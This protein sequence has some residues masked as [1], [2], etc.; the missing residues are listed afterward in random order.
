LYLGP[1]E[2]A[3]VL[4]DFTAYAGKTLILYNDAPA[5]DPASDPRIDYFT[6]NGDQTG[7]GGAANT[8]PGYGPNT[9]TVMQ[10]VVG[11]TATA[12]TG[13]ATVNLGALQTAL[14]QAFASS[15]P[16]PVVPEPEFN[17]AYDPLTYKGA[18][19]YTAPTARYNTRIYTGVVYLGAYQGVSFTTP[20]PIQYLP[21]PTCTTAAAC[22]TAVASQQT[23]PKA[24]TGTTVVAGGNGLVSAPAGTA[25]SAYVQSKAIQELFDP[26]YG[27]MNATLGVELP[28]TSALTQTTIPLGYVDPITETV[29]DGETQFWKIT[30]NGVDAHPVHFHLVNVQVINRIGWDGTI[31][32]PFGDEFGWKDTV[33]MNPLEDIVVAVRAK[34]P[35]L[36]G[37][38][39]ADNI[40]AIPS[41]AFGLPISQR[42]RDPSQLAGSA[43]GFTQ[44]DPMTGNPATVTNSVQ[45]YGWEYVWHCHILG[46]EENDFMRPVKFDAKEAAAAIPTGLAATAGTTGG[47]KLTWAD[48]A[49]TEYAYKVERGVTTTTPAR[50]RTPASTTTTWTDLTAA[51][52]PAQQVI[53]AAPLANANTFTDTTASTTVGTV[54]SYRVTALAANGNGVSSTITYTVGAA[55]VPPTAPTAPTIGTIQRT[56]ATAATLTWTDMSTNEKTFQVQVSNDGGTTWASATGT[57]VTVT[58]ANAAAATSINGALSATVTVA[59]TTNASYRVQVTGIAT[60]PAVGLTA[61]SAV[62][63]LND[64][65]APAAATGFNSTARFLNIVNFTWTDVANNNASYALQSSANGTTWTNVTTN[66]AGGATSYLANGQRTANQTYRVV[67]VN[68]AVTSTTPGAVNVAGTTWGIPSNTKLVP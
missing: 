33:K 13:A 38:T 48:V 9:R 16:T 42:L 20:E 28:F 6:G 49:T 2:R 41:N 31:K 21:A 11:S 24:P 53:G 32:A 43:I 56:S 23:T 30:H 26:A 44:V 12:G 7:A 3:D 8:L 46:H 64:T 58:R 4:V 36:K 19:K 27:R 37:V 52:T 25:V 14:P 1:A 68:S 10:I 55:V 18:A 22:A 34:K 15:Q 29:A 54:Y 66:I 61:A 63:T 57:G 59:N 62:V 51:V 45:S 60:A 39:A 17:A 47:V 67:A 5:P 35:L 50:G 40:T 65:V